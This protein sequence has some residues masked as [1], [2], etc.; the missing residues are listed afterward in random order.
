MVF[1]TGGQRWVFNG[2]RRWNLGGGGGA[3]G[4]V[5]ED[6][7]GGYFERRTFGANPHTDTDPHWPLNGGCK[8]RT[9]DLGDEVVFGEAMIGIFLR[10]FLNHE[11]WGNF[12]R[13]AA[14][15]LKLLGMKIFFIM[16]FLGHKL[17]R[18]GPNTPRMSFETGG[19]QR[20]PHNEFCRR[21]WGG[22]W[23]AIFWPI[24]LNTG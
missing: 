24:F 2:I 6:T 1:D 7:S 21:N 20:T 8:F 14:M 22:G 12:F 19:Q 9:A 18:V 23:W 4:D 16:D 11:F 15:F 13:G 5:L 10:I 3:G 17:W